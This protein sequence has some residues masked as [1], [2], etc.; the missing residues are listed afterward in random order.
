MA[1]IYFPPRIR[2][3]D[4]NGMPVPGALVTFYNVG[5]VALKAIY[6]DSLLTVPHANPVVADSAGLLPV[7]YLAGAYKIRVTDSLGTLIYPEVDNLDAPLSTS[8]GVLAISAGGTGADTASGARTALG[9]P[10][11]T[12]FD[13]LA[14]QVGSI[15]STIGAYPAFGALAAKSKAAPE[16]LT[17]G[18]APVCIQRVTQT[19]NVRR[20]LSG[21][22]PFDNTTPL[23]NEGDTI[24][25]QAF[26]PKKAASVIRVEA[27]IAINAPDRQ[28]AVTLFN[29]TGPTDPAIAATSWRITSNGTVEY[30]RLYHEFASPGTSPITIQINAGSNAGYFLNGTNT[31]GLFNGLTLSRLILEEFFQP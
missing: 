21:I 5:T 9:V 25:T 4:L 28:I 13:A 22:I 7:I 18:F 15:A 11:Q 14:S 19:D 31:A 17:N 23:R 1:A 2:I 8:G 6:Q 30:L 24:F 26:T 10:S 29:T 3:T 12:T 16:D 27:I 20:T